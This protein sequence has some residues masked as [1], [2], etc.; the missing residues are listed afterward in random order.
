MS[1][2]WSCLPPAFQNRHRA[3]A[4]EVISKLISNSMN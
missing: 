1:K 3:K 4:R 2:T